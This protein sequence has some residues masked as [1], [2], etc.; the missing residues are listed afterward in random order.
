M[1][2][3]EAMIST[4]SAPRPRTPIATY[5]AVTID[6]FEACARASEE[7]QRAA[8]R[9][10]RFAPAQYALSRSADLVR[11]TAATHASWSRWTLGL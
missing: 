3:V 2:N 4:R 9:S 5:A 10:V 7:L 6:V 8:A 1:G 11:D